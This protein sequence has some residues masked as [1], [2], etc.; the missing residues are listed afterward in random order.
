MKVV[1]IADKSTKEKKAT[2]KEELK[3]AADLL[4]INLRRL[5][6]RAAKKLING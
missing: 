3:Q 5:D 4:A 2:K 1:Y 6:S